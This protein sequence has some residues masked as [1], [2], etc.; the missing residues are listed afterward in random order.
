MH[1]MAVEARKGVLDLLEP[2]LQ[3]AVSHH[4]DTVD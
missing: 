1:A 3:M 4:V 2:Q